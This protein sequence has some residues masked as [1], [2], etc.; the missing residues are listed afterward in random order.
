[1]LK[2]LNRLSTLRIVVIGDL[3]LDHYIW[4]E[5]ERISPE[6]PVPVVRVERDAYAAGGAAN[7][8]L[9]LAALGAQ[10]RVLGYLGNDTAG[11]RLGNILGAHKVDCTALSSKESPTIIKTRVMAR[12]QQVCRID[13][14]APRETYMQETDSYF[15]DALDD[16]LGGVDAVIMSDYAKGAVTQTLVDRVLAA[17]KDRPSLLVAVDPKPSRHLQIRGAGLLTPNRSESLELAGISGLRSDDIFPLEE[18][19]SRIHDLYAPSQ[20]VITLGPEGMAVSRDGSVV[21]ILPTEAR[22]VFDVSGAGD[23]V[24]ASL[25]A[26]LA[27]GATPVEAARFSNLAASCVVAHMG[28]KPIVRGELVQLLNS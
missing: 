22:E 1:M 13:R 3:M 12:S 28:T 24:I 15:D 19:C 11:R 17:A 2:L 14:E 4:G 16:V 23:T 5:V 27:A 7:V 8:A 26:A 9:N 25:T 6:A 20:L 21:E 10:V 18:V